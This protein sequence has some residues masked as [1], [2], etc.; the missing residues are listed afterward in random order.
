MESSLFVSTSS[1]P[2]PSLFSHPY[3]KMRERESNVQLV[4]SSITFF[5]F[6]LSFLAP[7]PSPL[8]PSN[9]L[10]DLFKK[11]K[12]LKREEEEKERVSAKSN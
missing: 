3:R 7:L 11:K 8:I 10:Y 12:E 4:Y 1:L 2:P 9:H 6:S 5:L